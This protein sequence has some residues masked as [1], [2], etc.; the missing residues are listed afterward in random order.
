MKKI[1][2]WIVVCLLVYFCCFWITANA[3]TYSILGSSSADKTLITA[4][5][6]ASTSW[7]SWESSGGGSWWS[8]SWG[9][10][11]SWGSDA[12]AWNTW[13]NWSWTLIDSISAGWSSVSWWKSWSNW[14]NPTWADNSSAYGWEVS[15]IDESKITT[16]TGS[17]P[18]WN[19]D[20]SSG[21]SDAQSGWWSSGGSSG[22]S[23]TQAA[24]SST[25]NKWDNA[26][27]FI[28]VNYIANGWVFSNNEKTAKVVYNKNDKGLYIS[29]QS[30]TVNQTGYMFGWWYSEPEAKNEW[31]GLD[32]DLKE[33]EVTVYAKWLPFEDKE[34][35]F[36]WN[37]SF[38]IM[39]RNLGA[40]NP[41]KNYSMKNNKED[42]FGYYYQWWNNYW[43][44]SWIINPKSWTVEITNTT[45]KQRWPGNF[46]WR[47][48]YMWYAYKFVDNNKKENSNLWWWEDKKAKDSDKQWPCPQWYHVP[49][50]SEWIALVYY[51]NNRNK[52]KEWVSYCWKFSSIAE[53]FA[54][55]L[56]LPMADQS[57]LPAADTANAWSLNIWR[58]WSSTAEDSDTVHAITFYWKFIYPD[59]ISNDAVRASIRCFKDASKFNKFIIDKDDWKKYEEYSLR[60]WE[61]TDFYNPGIPA[62]N[63]YVFNGWYDW[64]WKPYTFTNTWYLLA[65]LSIK[66]KWWYTNNFLP[67]TGDK[68]AGQ[69]RPDGCVYSDG[70]ANPECYYW[71]DTIGNVQQGWESDSANNWW[72][73]SAGWADNAATNK[74]NYTQEEKELYEWAYNN[75]IT[76]M[77]SIDK[78]APNW[79]VKR[80][81]M[82]KMIVNFATNIL[83]KTIPTEG[84]A[85]CAWSDKASDWENKE[86]KEYAKK[87][88]ALWYMWVNKKKFDPNGVVTRAEFWTVLSRILW[89]DKY[90]VKSPSVLTNFYSAHLENLKANWI[91]TKIEEAETRKELRVRVWM[92]LKRVQEMLKK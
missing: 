77:D 43:F 6:D 75:W 36:W 64:E 27:K 26:I 39:D 48:L 13:G 38:T 88:C 73:W 18:S 59:V 25:D 68:Q 72:A 66:A 58:Y 31:L 54:D 65:P 46:F 55:K 80:W 42:T 49:N 70:T 45:S 41:L 17:Q 92:M 76:T 34:I 50:S 32:N 78:A 21:G 15:G 12:S 47:S 51:F 91:M 69:N 8:A 14:S 7:S 11:S 1:W 19:T 35:D 81:H 9:W 60:R 74:Y 5:S 20:S 90:D 85:P 3:S 83:W 63:G 16:I 67:W 71:N 37:V 4:W 56:W 61:P 82:A 24:P 30:F 79:T 52:T 84:S 87:A 40:E 2:W 29:D 28:I 86:I 10:S 23:D 53:C 89:W 62:K 33:Q 22:G 44:K 57:N